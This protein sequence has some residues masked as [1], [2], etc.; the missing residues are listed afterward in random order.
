MFKEPEMRDFEKKYREKHGV[1]LSSAAYWHIANGLLDVWRNYVSRSTM[2][3]NAHKIIP[4]I[5]A[6][7]EGNL[8]LLEEERDFFLAKFKQYMIGFIWVCGVF[9]V[10]PVLA[11]W[12]EEHLSDV[13]SCKLFIVTLKKRMYSGSAPAALGNLMTY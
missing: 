13:H 3:E 11:N 12:F 4:H 8:C 9:D 2:C 6:K 7:Y 10:E 5:N 1:A